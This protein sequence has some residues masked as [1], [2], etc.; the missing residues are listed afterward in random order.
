MTS[1]KVYDAVLVGAGIM[2]ATMATLLRELEPSWRIAVIERLEQPGQESSGP[3]HNA[4]TGHSALC[5]LNYTPERADGSVDV[6]K[7]VQIHGQWQES[8]QLWASLVRA[9]KL[10]ASFIRP[11]P[12]MS[13]VCGEDVSFLRKR[14][15]AMTKHPFFAAMEFTTEREQVREWAPLLLEG[16]S[17]DE[18]I[19]VTRATEGTDVDFGRLTE[20]LLAS[21]DATV[22]YSTEVKTLRR[23]RGLWRVRAQN[24]SGPLRLT[25]PYVFVGAGGATLPL[26]QKAGLRE[27]RGY[28]GFPISGKFWHTPKAGVVSKHRVK[29]Y[30]RAGVNAPPMS[31]PH[32]DAREIQGEG[33][34]LFGPFAGFSPR[35]LKQGHLWDLASSLRWHNLLPMVSV[36]FSNTRLV[37]Y[38]ASELVASERKKLAEVRKFYPQAASEDWREIIAGQRVQV[39]KPVSRFR[40]ELQF[41]TEVIVGAQGSMAGLLGASP[42]ASTAAHVMVETLLKSFPS[43]RSEWESKLASLIPSTALSVEEPLASLAATAAARSVLKLPPVDR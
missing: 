41:G 35:F 38:L 11:V 21:S 17:K 2:G 28:G 34:L 24:A 20:G 4:G 31:V 5:E 6:S 39:I 25:A 29:V 9:G 27:V 8:L 3:W 7:A 16:R 36:A 40:G 23:S 12:H 13:F 32:L 30:G 22:F 37:K 18:A 14:H 15:E 10:E 33:S 1:V 43:K 42:G 26:L 19:A